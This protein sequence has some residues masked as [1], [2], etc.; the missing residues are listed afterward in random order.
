[1]KTLI[2]F[3]HPYEGS[4]CRTLLDAAVDGVRSGGSEADVINL[5]KDGFNPVM[6]AKDLLAFT[7][8]R[9]DEE[10]AL[11][12]L[13]AKVLQYKRSLERVEHLVF[14]FPIWWSL[15]PALTKG[16]IDKVIFPGIAYHYGK[17][18]AM[19]SSLPM[20]KKVTIVTTMNT[21]KGVYDTIIGNTV[22]RALKYGT[23]VTIGVN[24]VKWL[25]FNMVKQSSDE[26]RKEWIEEVRCYFGNVKEE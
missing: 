18:D 22:W 2:V 21:P 26:T 10:R 17:D 8:A 14:M 23:F 4:F 11:D 7:V 20:L 25:S 12:M 24:D 6:T 19:H 1:M 5:D 9:N 16:F 15:M 3:N 13:D